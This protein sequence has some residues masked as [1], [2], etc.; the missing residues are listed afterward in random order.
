MK[1]LGTAIVESILLQYDREEVLRRFSDPCWFQSL[2]CTLG[3]DWHS[4]GL[5]TVLCGALKEGINPRAGDYGIF[6]AGGKGAA[7]RNTPGEIADFADRHSPSLPVET[8]QYNSRLSAKVDSGAIQDGYQIYHHNFIVT[9]NGNWSVIQQGM[10]EKRGWARR[11]HWISDS[12]DNLVEEPHEGICANDNLE[13][14]DLTSDASR[15][16]RRVTSEMA[17]ED[18]DG[19]LEEYKRILDY[20]DDAEDQLNLP[21]RHDIPNVPHLDKTLSK[22]YDRPVDNFETLLA[23]EG[24]GPKTVRALSM[25]AEVVWGAEPSYEDPA[26]YAFAHGGND[27]HPY[28]VRRK[29]YD[30]TTKMLGNALKEAKIGRTEKIKALKRLASFRESIRS[31][32]DNK[33]N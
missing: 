33:R 5:T 20:W 21:S 13:P 28:P 11:Y 6:V 16:N 31:S 22:L 12:V 3:F 9:R 29:R 4:S 32:S 30:R 8:L 26:R 19:V 17:N 7:S 25:I 10:N 2:G 23:T 18:P 27:G 15:E 1:K 24:V 14:L